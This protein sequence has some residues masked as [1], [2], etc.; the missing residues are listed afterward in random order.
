MGAAP[1]AVA[2]AVAALALA[3]CGAEPAPRPGAVV[4][5]GA[6]PVCLDRTGVEETSE[7]PGALARPRLGDAEPA[8]FVQCHQTVERVPGRGEW[9]VRVERRADAG[10]EAL[11]AALRLPDQ[12]R[13]GSCDAMAVGVPELWALDGQGRATLVRWPVGACGKPRA[14]VSDAYGA[15]R[16]GSVTSRP[17]AQV[18]PQEALDSG[19]ETAVKDMAAIDAGDA[20]REHPAGRLGTLVDATSVKA[21]TYTVVDRSETPTGSFVSGRTIDGKAWQTVRRALEAAPP[22]PRACAGLGQRFTVLSADPGGEVYLELDGCRR[23][24]LPYGSL[25]LA[26]PALLRAL[27]A[28]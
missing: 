18:A 11:A 4:T 23:V 7:Q 19:C 5:V 1:R 24:L 22:A 6:G 25:R 2:L 12:E 10:T 28:P 26:T 15:V 3:G 20:S 9:S 16:W 8:G 13:G 17:V 27:A 14:E 21:C